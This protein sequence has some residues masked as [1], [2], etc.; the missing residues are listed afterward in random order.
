[1]LASV[2][3]ANAANPV[4]A[5][6]GFVRGGV[7][8]A[9]EYAD[10]VAG[11]KQDKIGGGTAGTVITNTGTSG[12][13]GSVA[14]D[15]AVTDGSSNLVTSDAV[16]EAVTTMAGG[17]QGVL[18]GTSGSVATYTGADGALGEKAVDTSAASGSTNL[19]TSGAVYNGLAAKEDAIAG[20][21]TNA[22]KVIIGT[23]TGYEWGELTPDTYTETQTP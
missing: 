6:E 18:S 16:Y 11:G 20:G 15:T 19:I 14:I 5:T 21:T 10:S 17:S 23:Q 4:I 8:S 3:A 22:G 13:V 1:M 2:G 12:T 7:Q 9:K